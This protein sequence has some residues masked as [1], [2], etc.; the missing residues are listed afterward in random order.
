MKKNNHLKSVNE[1]YIKHMLTALKYSLKFFYAAIVVLIHAAYP[2]WH[3][4]TAS[5]IAKNIVENVSV[6]H[7]K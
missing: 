3:Q 6:R 4:N 1:K 7:K 5:N 2:Q